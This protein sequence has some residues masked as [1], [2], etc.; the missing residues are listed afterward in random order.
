MGFHFHCSLLI[1]IALCIWQII[2]INLPVHLPTAVAVHKPSS[3]GNGARTVNYQLGTRATTQAHK[4]KDKDE[5]KIQKQN[6]TVT[7]LAL[8]FTKAKSQKTK[9]KQNK[10]TGVTVTQNLRELY[11][12]CGC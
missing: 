11:G 9:Q 10:N 7:A 1:L 5:D 8:Y 6:F 3:H 4:H 12:S 2:C